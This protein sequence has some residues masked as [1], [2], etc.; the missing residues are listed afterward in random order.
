M[1][2]YPPHKTSMHRDM[3]FALHGGW[4]KKAG[5]PA[6]RRVNF[7]QQLGRLRSGA[8]R[9][10]GDHGENGIVQSLVVAVALHNQSW[11]LLAATP[12]AEGQIR[13]Y[14]IAALYPH[15]CRKCVS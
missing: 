9:N 2:N 13:Q 5:F 4:V 11:P 3:V 14:N 15:A 7:N 8:L 12:V 6:L 1:A 10:A